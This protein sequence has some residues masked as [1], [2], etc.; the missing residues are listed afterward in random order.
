MKICYR[1]CMHKTQEIDLCGTIYSYIFQAQISC[2]SFPSESYYIYDL[3]IYIYIYILSITRH[4]EPQVNVNM[5]LKVFVRVTEIIHNDCDIL[6]RITIKRI[7]V[8]AC[9][10]PFTTLLQDLSMDL[11]LFKTSEHKSFSLKILLPTQFITWT[12]KQ[13]VA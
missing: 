7:L 9:I 6:F 4:V 13:N 5:F 10:N 11:E 1:N 12:I 8:M 3:Y 2:I